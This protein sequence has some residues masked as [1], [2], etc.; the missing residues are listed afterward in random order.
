[1]QGSKLGCVEAS[2]ACSK[3]GTAVCVLGR[4]TACTGT[5][6]PMGAGSGWVACCVEREQRGMKELKSMS[7]AGTL[8]KGSEVDVR[9][10]RASTEMTLPVSPLMRKN[11]I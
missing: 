6:N 10:R 5:A 4:R 3:W 7:S 2:Y 9:V 1:M 11:S 8:G